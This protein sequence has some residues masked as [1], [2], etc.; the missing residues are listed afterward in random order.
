MQ[1]V[2]LPNKIQDVELIWISDN[3]IPFWGHIYTNK[4]SVGYLKFKFDLVFSISFCFLNQAI[5]TD[6]FLWRVATDVWKQWFRTVV[7]IWGS[8]SSRI[9][10]MSWFGFP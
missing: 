2:G 1:F 10:P 6:G 4:L 5:L 3:H 8:G 9:K 7:E